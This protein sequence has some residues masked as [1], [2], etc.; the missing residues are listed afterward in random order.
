MEPALALFAADPPESIR[1]RARAVRA[2]PKPPRRRSSNCSTLCAQT[3]PRH[4]KTSERRSELGRAV[5]A[6]RLAMLTDLGLVDDSEL[7]TATG[8][9]APRLVR[10]SARRAGVLVATL[11]QTA[12]GVGLADLA[13]NL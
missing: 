6:D 3:G 1:P 13:G 12:I 9:R 11:D 7:G 5:V 4:A 2:R 10:F 8:G